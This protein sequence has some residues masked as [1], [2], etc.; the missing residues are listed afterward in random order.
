MNHKSWIS[1]LAIVAGAAIYAP[2]AE[3]QNRFHGLDR[4]RDGVITRGEW[5]GNDTSFRT[6][7]RNGDGIIS[8]TEVRHVPA[9]PAR[10]RSVGTSGRDDAPKAKSNKSKSRSNTP[11]K[12]KPAKPKG[13]RGHGNG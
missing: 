1:A 3:A 4:N 5:R 2:A 12:T 11:A 13:G 9:W 8:G 6:H 7:D 10:D